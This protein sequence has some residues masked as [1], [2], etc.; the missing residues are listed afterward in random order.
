MPLHLVAVRGG[1]A[2]TLRALERNGLVRTL[3]EPNLTAVSGESAN[4]LAGGEFP[5]PVATEDNT[6]TI[7][8]KEFGVG[9]A[10][11]PVVM[12]E[13]RISLKISTEVSELSTNGAVTFSSI[14]IP[15]LSK[16]KTESTVEL[17]SGGTLAISGLVSNNIQKNIDGFPGLKE[18]P[19]LG[20]LFRSTDFVKQGDRT[21][22]DRHAV[23][24]TADESKRKLAAPTDGLA[25]ATDVK[26]YL[27]GHLN[28]IHG[29]AVR[30]P[31]G[32]LKDS[33]GF[34]VE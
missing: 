16:R 5:I 28:R 2:Y 11:T 34:I 3:A 31:P 10:F 7:E 21:R 15:A 13:G 18:L 25:P 17:P 33:Y 8:F 1:I 32:S 12:S 9:L 27:L 29:R 19:I 30:L 26:T 20:T 22:R 4:F 24:R 6:V 23:Y 14:A